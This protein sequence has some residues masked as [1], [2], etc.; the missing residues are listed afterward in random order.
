MGCPI[1]TYGLLVAIL[2]LIHT[3]VGQDCTCYDTRGDYLDFHLCTCRRTWKEA[4]DYCSSVY[5][6]RLAKPRDSSSQEII[7]EFLQ[8][9][10]FADTW[11]GGK[12][13]HDD[14]H[15]TNGE[16]A[17]LGQGCWRD[18]PQNRDLGSLRSLAVVTPPN[19]IEEC[20]NNGYAYAGLQNG[21]QCF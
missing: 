5:N 8:S 13:D 14:W 2:M 19:C 17:I 10:T 20:R 3:T 7:A 16:E 12:G 21:F 4:Q 9:K 15:W 18:D 6:G 1:K 11:V